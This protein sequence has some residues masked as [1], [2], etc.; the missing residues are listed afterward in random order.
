M[1]A[2][3][4]R[5]VPS[6]ER[7]ESDRVR[8]ILK[9]RASEWESA[10][11]SRQEVFKFTMNITSPDS[12]TDHGISWKV[13]FESVPAVHALVRDVTEV[14]AVWIVWLGC[15]FDC[16]A[17]YV[18]IPWYDEFVL[19]FTEGDVKIRYLVDCILLHV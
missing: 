16:P 18:K 3:G 15:G 12:A 7:S 19:C 14:E 11:E 5:W 9:K 17:L 4:D 2:E 10:R 1:V 13:L 8:L 6:I